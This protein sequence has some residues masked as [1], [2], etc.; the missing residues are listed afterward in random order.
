MPRLPPNAEAT[1]SSQQKVCFEQPGIP[2]FHTGKR[3]VRA[4][5][6]ELIAITFVSPRQ[7]MRIKRSR[8]G[9]KA[10]AA[11]APKTSLLRRNRDIWAPRGSIWS[12]VSVIAII[13]LVAPPFCS[14]RGPSS[15][16][17]SF[18]WP[19][20]PR[21]QVKAQIGRCRRRHGSQGSRRNSFQSART[22]CVR[23]SIPIVEMRPV[24]QQT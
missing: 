5:T 22:P 15:S 14:A 1:W 17:A 2:H 24:K 4:K 19:R 16:L 7:G 3:F 10:S 6:M 18:F 21:S 12:L 11:C 13:A 20:A 9:I 23:R 8:Y